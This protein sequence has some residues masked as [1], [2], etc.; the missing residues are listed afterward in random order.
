MSCDVAVSAALLL[1]SLNPGQALAPRL[2]PAVGEAPAAANPL[3]REPLFAGIV[4]E[5]KALN[6]EVEAYRKGLGAATT[7]KPLPR[8]DRFQKR[9]AALAELD[10]K[11]HLELAARGTD[12]DLKCILKGI[13][14]DLPKKLDE[15]MKAAGPKAQ[16]AALRDM[17]Y[18][19]NDNVE[20][21]TAPPAPP[22]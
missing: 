7:A 16:D 4:G 5:A 21:I 11:G 2:I 1:A 6:A 14:Q 10:M 13:A 17:A 12:G 22:V 18:L 20:V 15:L 8:L 9:I 19:L 3:A